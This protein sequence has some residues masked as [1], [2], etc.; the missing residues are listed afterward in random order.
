MNL[1]NE[2]WSKYPTLRWQIAQTMQTIE[3][4][5]KKV[6][7]A[8]IAAS[9]LSVRR[10]R[11]VVRDNGTR[12]HVFVTE[13]PDN[14]QFNPKKPD[15]ISVALD[16]IAASKRPDVA[17]D[18]RYWRVVESTILHE[19]VHWADFHID[20]NM[21]SGETGIAFEEEAYD[22]N[23]DPFWL[24][25]H[26]ANCGTTTLNQQLIHPGDLL[27]TAPKPV[28]D[29]PF[30]FGHGGCWPI[31]TTHAK[32]NVISYVTLAGKQLGEPSRS[33]LAQR[34]GRPSE[35]LTGDRYHV[36]IDLYGNPGDTVVACE[37]G[38]I[39]GIQNFYSGTW[40]MLVLG[41]SG[42][43]VNYG[44]VAADSWGGLAI[45]SIVKKGQKLAVLG[46]LTQGGMCHFETYTSGTRETARWPRGQ[47]RPT[48]LLN[49]IKYLLRL[50]PPA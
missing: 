46:R 30:A 19:L 50:Q 37:D 43:V 15:Q 33:F 35:S 49:P 4:Q 34:A 36:G 28:G 47:A 27:E 38:E 20:G 24:L 6:W 45:G 22:E 3:N 32:R 14:G 39:V 41:Q 8:F 17:N 10:A 1:N 31:R 40:A 13:M 44:E 26:E 7:N 2:S 18:G 23:V 29:V 48:N 42:I 21:A 16:I 11:D 9:G 25:G 12:P 5:N